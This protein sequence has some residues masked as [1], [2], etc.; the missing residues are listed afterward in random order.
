[1]SENS[2]AFWNSEETTPYFWKCDC[3]YGVILRSENS[4]KHCDAIGMDRPDAQRFQVLA[5]LPFDHIIFGI[6][7]MKEHT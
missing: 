4:C 2:P 3:T 6:E 5:A 7:Y 1:M